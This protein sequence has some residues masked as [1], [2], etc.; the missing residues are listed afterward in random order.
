[1]AD[2]NEET[3]VDNTTP[4]EETVASPAKPIDPSLEGIQL[5]YAKNKNLVNYAGGGLLVLIAAI[6]YFKF[7]Y[8]PEQEKAAE[9]EL[10]W[11]ESYFEKDSFN[12][13]LKGGNNVFAADGQ[14]PMMGFEQIADE[15]SLTKQGNLAAYY[16]GICNLRTGKFEQAIEW[17]SKYSGSDEIV[18]PI[19]IGATG[20]A[21]L[22]LKHYDEAYK[23]YMKASETSNNTFTTP[24]YLKKAALA[25]EIKGSSDEAIA[26][27]ERIRTEFPRSSEAA[28]VTKDIARLQALAGK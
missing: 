12:L 13:A 1:M 2:L 11:A 7:M 18:A 28:D 24:I 14:K 22:E 10:F 27:L 3:T 16:A 4:V 25:L 15:Y 20:D 6:V 5:F 23:F 9:N 17:L 21:H 8:L 19:A 26:V